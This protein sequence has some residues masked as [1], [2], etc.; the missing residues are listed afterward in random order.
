LVTSA[1]L[2]FSSL[3]GSEGLCSPRKLYVRD[4]ELYI[5]ESGYGAEVDPAMPNET[6]TCFDVRG[7]YNCIGSTSRVSKIPL[8]GGAGTWTP[9]LEGLFSSG[10]VMAGDTNEDSDVTGAQSVAF[11]DNG[12]LYTVIGLGLNGTLLDERGIDSEYGSYGAILKGEDPIAL[13]WVS[14]FEYN[15]DGGSDSTG[16]LPVPDSNPYHLL[17]SGS[18]YHLV[19]ITLFK[20]YSAATAFEVPPFAVSS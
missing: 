12:N 19:R 13:P 14:E 15:Y 11:D 3:Q 16:V 20:A 10:P 4:G 8:A 17:I 6:D 9:I 18:K 1:E 2:N 7:V 5:A